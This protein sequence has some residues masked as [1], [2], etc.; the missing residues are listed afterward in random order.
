MEEEEEGAASASAFDPDPDRVEPEFGGEGERG[1][2]EDVGE[3]GTTF[4]PNPNPNP[5]P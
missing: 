1:G 2:E 5:S 4:N 3:V